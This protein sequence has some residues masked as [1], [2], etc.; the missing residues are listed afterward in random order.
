MTLQTKILS[1]RSFFLLKTFYHRICMFHFFFAV[2]QHSREGKY[3]LYIQIKCL[4]WRKNHR[5]FPIIILLLYMF[6]VMES[7]LPLLFCF[8]NSGNI[9]LL[10]LFQCLFSLQS[11]IKYYFILIIWNKSSWLPTFV[12]WMVNYFF[13][14]TRWSNYFYHKASSA[15]EAVCLTAP[16]I[17][18]SHLPT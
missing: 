3:N 16:W 9:Y 7:R 18:H 1:S 4:F 14:K 5:H 17:F 2:M 10:L 13:K 12:D 6:D 8:Y 15:F 11:I